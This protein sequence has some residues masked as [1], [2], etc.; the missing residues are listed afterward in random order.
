MLSVR[1]CGTKLG[2]GEGGCGACT[3]MVSKYDRKNKKEMYPFNYI[4]SYV[5][6]WVTQY[7]NINNWNKTRECLKVKEKGL[8]LTKL[9][10]NSD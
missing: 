8:I 6:E 1:L 3:V 7:F 4:P 5:V 9:N 2:C 10:L